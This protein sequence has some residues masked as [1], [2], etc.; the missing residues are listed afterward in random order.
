MMKKHYTVGYP[1]WRIF[2]KFGYALRI[3][4]DIMR[5][6]DAGVF[7]ATSRDLRG[8]VCEGETVESV[9]DDIRRS[10]NVLLLLAY[11]PKPAPPHFTELNYL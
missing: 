10:A 3:R 4:V 6:Y 7:V 8:L 5:D 1:L 2:A 11:E 9:E